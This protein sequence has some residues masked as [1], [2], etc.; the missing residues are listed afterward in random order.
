MKTE[1]SEEF[2][3][4]AEHVIGTKELDVIPMTRGEYNQVRGWDIPADEDPNDPGCIVRYPD[5]YV[6]WSPRYAIDESYRSMTRMNFGQAIHFMKEGYRVA[7]AGWNGKDMFIYFVAGTVVDI[8]KLR[9]TCADAVASSQNT[10]PVQNINGHID[11]F[12]ATGDVQP[13]WLAS[14]TDMLADDWCIV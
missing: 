2:W 1:L 13:G 12:T 7:R 8:N 3:A 5:G 14:Q 9:G 6:S 10:A 4:T 11:M